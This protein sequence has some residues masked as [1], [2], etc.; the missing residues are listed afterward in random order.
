MSALL[1]LVTQTSLSGDAP[2]NPA[3]A[4]PAFAQ[5]RQLCEADHGQLWGI[6]LCGP[7]MLVDPATRDVIASE[8]DASGVLH[9][10]DGVFAGSLPKDVPVANTSVSWSGTRWIQ[11]LWPL[12]DDDALRRVLLAHESFH[13]VQDQL[14]LAAANADNPQLDTLEGRYDLQLEWRALAA[15]LQAHDDAARRAHV[16]DALAFRADRYR[17]F[18]SARA[19]EAALERNEGLAEYTGVMVG[20]P[21]ASERQAMALR[22]LQRHVHDQSFVRSFA[23]ATGPAYGLLLDNYRPGWHDEVRHGAYPADLLAKSL[24]LSLDK[25]PSSAKRAALAARYDGK[26]LWAA[27]TRRQQERDRLIAAYRSALISGHVL[28]LPL[29]HP[30]VQFDPRNLV[31]I[32]ANGTV[33]PTMQASDDW[34]HIEVQQGCLLAS[35]WS[36]L[37]VAAPS[38]EEGS[39]ISGPGWKL[40]LAPGWHLAKGS[41]AGDMV[42]AK[43]D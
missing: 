16:A 3:A 42:V 22:D 39:H 41:R 13:R 43:S 20:M 11:Y 26:A 31:P 40:E 9:A 8:K 34:G 6:S 36:W 23:Y 17:R 25:A 10:A 4:K 28:V 35:D 14:G 24:G 18:P 37:T 5:A 12:P 32:G 7:A 19:A 2:L 38:G 15:A 21:T 33:Y 30:R 29:R 1:L 27:E